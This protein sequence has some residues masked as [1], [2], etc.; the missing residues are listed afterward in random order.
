MPDVWADIAFIERG[1]R[2][3][4]ICVGFKTQEEAEKPPLPAFYL[5]NAYAAVGLFLTVTSHILFHVLCHWM[6]GFKARMLY[7]ESKP[8]Y[9]GCFVQVVPIE[10]RGKAEIVQVN[11]SRLTGELRFKFQRQVYEY[12]GASCQLYSLPLSIYINTG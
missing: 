7:T 12:Y 4:S 2:F 1:K 8:V 3:S 9:D 11:K 5:P 6:V 10:H